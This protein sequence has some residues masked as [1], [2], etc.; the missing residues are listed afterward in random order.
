MF[1]RLAIHRCAFINLSKMKFF[2]KIVNGIQPLTIIIKRFVLEVWQG[3][4]YAS[5]TRNFLNS[6]G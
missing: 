4:E 5:Y 1:L 6:F 2:A 3:L